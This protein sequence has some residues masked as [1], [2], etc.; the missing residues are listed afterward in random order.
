MLTFA[1]IA[2]HGGDIITQIADDPRTME[3]TRTAMREL[4]RRCAAARPDTVVVVT[5]HGMIPAEGVSIG[6]TKY[7]AGVLDKP[8]GRFI[9]ATFDVDTEL[10]AAIMAAGEAHSLPLYRIMG[11]ERREDAVLPLDWGA[12]IPLWFLAHPMKPRPKVVVLAPSSTLPRETLVRLG[13]AIARAAESSGKRVAF[14]ASGDQGHAHDPDGPYGYD[15]AS[16]AHDMA[17]CDAIEKNDL[18]QLLYWPPEFLEDAKVDA[19]YQTLILMG[20]MGH[21]PMRGELLSYEAPTYFGMAVAAY[22]PM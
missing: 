10:C 21:T 16:Q 8:D 1:A 3:K 17:M 18:D 14:V 2:P 7:A 12:L 11:D 9:K 13:V 19:F 15:S 20:L 6:F 4:G 5:P 22:E